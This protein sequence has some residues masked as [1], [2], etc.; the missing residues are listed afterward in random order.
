MYRLILTL[1]DESS[2]GEGVVPLVARVARHTSA[3]VLLL[4]AVAPRSTTSA[5]GSTPSAREARAH[6]EDAARWLARGGV[7]AETVVEEGPPA[8]VLLSAL[9]ERRPDLFAMSN[10]GGSGW[11]DAI[12]EIGVERVLARSPAPLLLVPASPS[13]ERQ[14]AR[15]PHP[16]L[17]VPLDGSARAEAALPHAVTL[18]RALG[19]SLM[20]LQTICSPG[21]V[22][23][24]PALC[25]PS[26][27][28]A[29]PHQALYEAEMYLLGVAERLGREGL[30]PYVVIR[31]GR[32]PEAIL[33]EGRAGTSIVVMATRGRSGRGRSPAGCVA[34][35]VIRRGDLPLLVIGPQALP[36][37]RRSQAQ[38]RPAGVASARSPEE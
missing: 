30:W 6:L 27:D 36:T 23:P 2:L 18:A 25:V 5:S 22:G 33:D 16:R 12:E 21:P 10:R 20:L 15:W 7:E 14:A 37:G 24:A 3:R 35:E 26:R 38:W 13:R 19:G 31:S 32:A 17:L 28:H 4:R 9:H 1:V 29:A 8:E 34:R 11:T